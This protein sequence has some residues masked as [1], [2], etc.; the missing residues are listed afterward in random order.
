MSSINIV[1]IKTFIFGRKS[2]PLHFYRKI[3]KKFLQKAL[4]SGHLLHIRPNSIDMKGSTPHRKPTC[5]VALDC[6]LE[7]LRRLND[8]ESLRRYIIQEKC[9]PPQVAPNAP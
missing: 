8:V 6:N 1:L 2:D 7:E 4:H 9:F 3:H 5:A